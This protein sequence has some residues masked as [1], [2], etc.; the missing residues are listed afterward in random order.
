MKKP[1]LFDNSLSGEIK[2]LIQEAKQRV[3]VSVNIELTLLYWQV[4][5]RISSEVLK[6]K[7]A[8]Y[9]KKIISNLA[10][11]LTRAFGRG[12]SKKQLHHC[13]RFAETFPDK[14][15][16]SAVQRQLSW[17][18]LKNLIYMDDPLKREF[19]LTM[20][21]QERWSTRT[22]SQRIDAQLFER[23]AISKKPDKTIARELAD[24]RDKGLVNEN[25]ILKDP[26]V[27]DFLELNDTYLEK[28]LED[29]IL[30]D[31]Q[32]FLLELGSGFTFIARQFRIQVDNEDYYIDLLFYNRKLK[33]L[34]AIDLKVGRFKAEYKG[35]MELYLRWLAKYEQESDEQTPLGIILCA[36]KN[37]EQ[38]ELLEMGES[39]IH[40]AQYLTTL[41]PREI[42]EQRLHQA[43]IDAKL[44]LESKG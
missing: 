14:A 23:T 40:V 4:G 31:L 26:Y 41:P 39:G 43:I 16:V 10:Q 7:R 44:R 37:Q 38:I 3:A 21:V 2:Q 19:Y 36:G 34:I 9:G 8:E 15:I 33:R 24:L 27:L 6:N 5:K 13:L 12:W 29:A 28:D 11:D 32:Q 30:R 42:L 35:Q 22:L 25:L 17:T 20:T 1:L 18:H